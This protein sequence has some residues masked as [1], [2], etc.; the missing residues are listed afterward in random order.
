[1]NKISELMKEKELY[2]EHD[3]NVLLQDKELYSIANAIKVIYEGL[4]EDEKSPEDL[5]AYEWAVKEIN[6]Q[7]KYN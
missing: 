2:L 5:T 6:W 7:D 3:E 4:S 1:M